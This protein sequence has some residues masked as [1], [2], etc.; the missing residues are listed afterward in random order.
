ML[1][2]FFF[3]FEAHTGGEASSDIQLLPDKHEKGMGG[4][5]LGAAA[6]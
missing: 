6:S 3:R 1:E 4:E 2:G 5:R